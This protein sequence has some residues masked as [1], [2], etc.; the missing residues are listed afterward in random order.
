MAETA[1]RLQWHRGPDARGVWCDAR[2]ALAHTRLSIIDVDPRSDQ[3]FEKDGLVI[4]FNGEIYN[5]AEVRAVLERDHD[6]SFRTRSDTEVVLEAY[7]R[8]GVDGLTRLE[9]MFAFAVYERRS[10]NLFLARDRFGI[11]PLFFAEQHGRF[12]FAS[13]IKVLSATLPGPRCVDSRALVRALSYQWVQGDSTGIAGIRKL[14]PAHWLKVDASGRVTTGCYW[15]LDPERRFEGSDAAAVDEL[16]AILCAS[17][18]RHMV[19]DV[20]VGA[21][22]SGGIDSSLLAVLA[23]RNGGTL[24]TFTIAT[25]A[26][27]KAIERMPADEVYA[28]RVAELHGFLHDEIVI[29][30]DIANELPK[31]VAWLD[32]PIGDPAAINTYLICKAARASGVK[33]LLSGMGAD[34]IFFGYRRQKA[35][36]IAGRYS[37]LPEWI[38]DRV[39]GT[40]ER[41]PVRIGGRGLRTVRWA[42]RFLAF[43]SL[44]IDEAF[45]ASYSYYDAAEL[46]AL[47]PGSDDE[48]ARMIADHRRIFEAD[49]RGDPINQMC[50]TDVRLFMEG[51]NLTYT[52]RASMA[53]STEV[54]VPFI[55][56]A[57]VEFAMSLPGRLKY[58]RGRTKDV[59]KRVAERYLPDEV[60]HRPKA[61][62]GAPIRSWISGA[63]APLVDELL[64]RQNIVRRGLLDPD[65]VAS[66]VD[67]DRCGRADNAYRIY[68]LLTLELWFRHC[69]DAGMPSTPAGLS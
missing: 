9:G 20:E 64:S 26:A 30:P 47:F 49:Y 53:A 45:R 46:A 40:A 67:A 7:R 41:L 13:E 43:A 68:Q 29:H 12:A 16:D 31:A 54:R 48:I 38:R 6:V 34:E 2:L 61:S 10:G 50:N 60:V 24:R 55:D 39:R 28:R 1:N 4:V 51:L 15:R 59:L 8:F 69:V 37:R 22:L 36:L 57:V 62:F 3:P 19:A 23:T 17:V 52:D 65:V 66:I 56:R 21:F 27:D 14:A 32:Q 42:R 58:R 25:T 5:F 44:P 11:K 63:L 35:T 18:D 33:V